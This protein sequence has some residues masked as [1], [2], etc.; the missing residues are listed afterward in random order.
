M[1]MKQIIN[2]KLLFL[3]LLSVLFFTGTALADEKS[4]LFEEGTRLYQEGHFLEALDHYH[5]ILEMGYA[6]GAV[7]YNIGNCYY[8]LNEIGRAILYFE[9]AKQ[10]LPND[11]DLNANLALANL[12]VVDKIEPLPQ[13]I[14]I[15]IVKG[16]YN[17]FPSSFLLY[18]AGTLYLLTVLFLILWF[19]VRPFYIRQFGLRSSIVTGV[20]LVI[21]LLIFWGQSYENRSNV[22]AVILADTVQVQ[23]SPSEESTELFIL[24]A[25]TK[26]R[27]DQDRVDW[28]E[29]VLLDGKVGWVKKDILEVI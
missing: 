15:R 2:P 4:R 24:H 5:S 12:N 19:A 11:E 8:K 20:L 3:I 21:I 29:I 1:I 9:K 16:L 23:A 17:L 7:Y 14:L 13:F 25:G 10:F 27:I 18:S 6:S 28:V 22:E 26:V